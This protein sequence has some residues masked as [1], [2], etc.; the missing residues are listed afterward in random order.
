MF[1]NLREYQKQLQLSD[2]WLWLGLLTEDELCA[3]GREYQVSED[4]CTEHYRYRVFCNY[5]D[6]HR[7]LPPAMADALYELGREDP[8]QGMG[9]AMMRD[10]VSL[11]ECPADVLE[12]A[13]ASGESHLVKAVRGRKLLAE[14]NSGLTKALFE[15]CLK[16]GED[17]IQ[18]ELLARPELTRKQLEQLAE[19]GCN[20]A[21]RNM[22][23]VKLRD[24]HHAA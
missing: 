24:R 9:G 10:I 2:Q 22:A 1:M 7:P 12:K 15:R 14:L 5:L 21:V 11:K 13:L 3:L 16:S 17:Y 19:T 6:S 18:R 20:R 4:K 8:N 23:A